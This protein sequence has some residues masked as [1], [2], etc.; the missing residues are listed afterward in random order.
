MKKLLYSVLIA[1]GI[2]ACVE[3][4]IE[5]R[6]PASSPKNPENLT[7]ATGP[8]ELGAQEEQE[9]R[10]LAKTPI[11]Q[12]EFE[13]MVDN[14]TMGDTIVIKRRTGNYLTIGKSSAPFTTPEL[15]HFEFIECELENGIIVQNTF[16][17]ILNIRRSLMRTV[18]MQTSGVVQSM[19]IR[20]SKI[21]EIVTIDGGE[22]SDLTLFKTKVPLIQNLG[23]TNGFL[24]IGYQ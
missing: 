11:T 14:A 15:L 8:G 4:D 6:S 2:S 12:E 22:I 9:I 18:R 1:F 21:Q 19:E 24:V 17:A 3:S 10:T 20:R 7:T 16:Q 5:S 23:T 13:A